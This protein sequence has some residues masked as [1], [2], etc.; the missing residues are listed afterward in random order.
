[1]ALLSLPQL[2]EVPLVSWFDLPQLDRTLASLTTPSATEQ[3]RAQALL[4]VRGVA[5]NNPSAV[6]HR[7]YLTMVFEWLHSRNK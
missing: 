7:G 3:M 6:I 4:I 2:V 1:M 5:R